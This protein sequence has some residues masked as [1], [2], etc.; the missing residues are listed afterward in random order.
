VTKFIGS[1]VDFDVF[2]V[3]KKQQFEITCILVASSDC[4]VGALHSRLRH[5]LCRVL[6]PY[7]VL[8]ELSTLTGLGKVIFGLETMTTDPWTPCIT[9]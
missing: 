5:A 3:L 4:L 1:G 9:N 2:I 6:S 7:K 8:L